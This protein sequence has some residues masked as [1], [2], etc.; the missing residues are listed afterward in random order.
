[1]VLNLCLRRTLAWCL[2]A[3]M[4]LGSLAPTVSRARAF[5]Q[6]AGSVSWTEI[7]T[8]QGVVNVA[9]QNDDAPPPATLVLDHCP[10]CVLGQDRLAPPPQPLVWQG[11]PQGPPE[12]P[13][14]S[15]PLAQTA[16]SWAAQ[17]RAPPV[18]S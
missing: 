4:M 6:G 11:L 8:S 12:V 9:V 7:C 3:M 5:L 16:H 17:P 18:F 1:M 14:S 13:R 10:L 2:L 15:T